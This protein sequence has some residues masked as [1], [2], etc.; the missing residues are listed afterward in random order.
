MKGAVV[1][2]IGQLTEE[3]F[4]KIQYSKRSDKALKRHVGID[5]NA[6]YRLGDTAALIPNSELYGLYSII[7]NGRT[8]YYLVVSVISEELAFTWTLYP[9]QKEGI[10]R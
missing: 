4:K 7:W 1:T 5:T 6:D 2:K 3:Q 8:H 10:D 9:V